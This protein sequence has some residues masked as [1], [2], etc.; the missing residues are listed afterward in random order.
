M[1]VV[2]SS[3]WIS[4]LHNFDTPETRKLD[5]IEDYDEIILGDI[6]LLEILRGARNDRN[7]ANIRRTLA[8]YNVAPMLSPELAILA[9]R[10]Y[11]VL[12]EHG[13]TV[14]KTPDLIIGTFCIEHGYSLLQKDKD[15]LPMAEHLG[16]RLV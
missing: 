12:R 9:A 6:V 4:R 10:N 5:E 11:R 16:L 14:S 7:A 1:I 3:V 13:K 8:R 15:Y 2:D